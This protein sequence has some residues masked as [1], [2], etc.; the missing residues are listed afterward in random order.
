M[1][2]L[3]QGFWTPEENAAAMVVRAHDD[4]VADLRRQ[5]AEAKERYADIE[6]AVWQGETG[7]ADHEGLCDEIR[8]MVRVL[9]PH[10]PAPIDEQLAE[11]Q[12]YVADHP[13][14]ADWIPVIVPAKDYAKLAEANAAREKA[15]AALDEKET[16]HAD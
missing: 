15:E 11:A 6:R 2:N 3:P 13:E 4:E 9:Q 12:R 10:D 5:L 16:P 7:R 14:A 8:R 1:P